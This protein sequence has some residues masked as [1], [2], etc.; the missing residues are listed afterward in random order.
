MARWINEGRKC[1]TVNCLAHTGENVGPL[2]LYIKETDT[3]NELIST[4]TLCW[5]DCSLHLCVDATP[6]SSQQQLHLS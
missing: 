1:F 5:A 4:L 2:Y 3:K 6:L